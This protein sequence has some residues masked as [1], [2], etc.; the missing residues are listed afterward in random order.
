MLLDGRETQ[1]RAAAML[2]YADINQQEIAAKLGVSKATIGRMAGGRKDSKKRPDLAY[3]VAVAE[4][5]RLPMDFFYADFSRL[6]EIVP[7]GV[8]V[9]GPRADA[10]PA[11]PDLLA[12]RGDAEHDSEAG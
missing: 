4:A 12:G 6:N 11:L 5:T 8:T 2:A 10:P 1:R 7:E 3:L 9:I